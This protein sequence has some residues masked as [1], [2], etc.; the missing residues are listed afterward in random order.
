[1][2]AHS[3]GQLWKSVEAAGE[4]VEGLFEGFGDFT[5]PSALGFH[6]GTWFSPQS[7]SFMGGIRDGANFKKNREF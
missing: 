1:M 4:V 6:G 2:L 3:H 7:G 5:S